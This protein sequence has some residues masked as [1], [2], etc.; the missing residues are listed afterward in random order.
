MNTNMTEF[1]VVFSEIFVSLCFRSKVASASEGLISKKK[2]QH[3]K[4]TNILKPLMLFRT[5]KM[6]IDCYGTAYLHDTAV[7]KLFEF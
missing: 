1:K 4:Q 2:Q 3:I 5:K 7:I 6:L